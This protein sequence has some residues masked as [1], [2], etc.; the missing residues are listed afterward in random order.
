MA[1]RS[2]TGRR[3]ITND[4]VFR[5]RDEED[6][7]PN[8]EI[9]VPPLR[10]FELRGNKGFYTVC[11]LTRRIVAIFPNTIDFTVERTGYFGSEEVRLC[12]S[13][14]NFDGKTYGDDGKWRSF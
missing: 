14:I 8:H 2:M 4:T 3:I 10:V 11:V 9:R 13:V 7:F 5:T 1:R 6:A 12:N